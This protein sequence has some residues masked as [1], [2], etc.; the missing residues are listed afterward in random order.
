MFEQTL[1]PAD[2]IYALEPPSNYTGVQEVFDSDPNAKVADN[3]W[4][5]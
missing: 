3:K 5:F 2:Y 1:F 4:Y